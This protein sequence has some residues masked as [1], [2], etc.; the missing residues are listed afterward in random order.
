VAGEGDRAALLQ[1]CLRIARE[2]K[3]QKVM[4]TV[5]SE[6]MQ[7]LRLGR[8]LGFTIRLDATIGLIRNKNSDLW[9]KPVTPVHVLTPLIYLFKFIS[10][11]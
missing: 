3:I 1:R 11:T 2:R 10:D 5:L 6:N 8:K 9:P 4:G 7:M